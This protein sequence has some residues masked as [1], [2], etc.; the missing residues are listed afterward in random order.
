MPARNCFAAEFVHELDADGK[1]LR[2]IKLTDD[3]AEKVRTLYASSDE[4]S[5][6]RGDA[7]QRAN[8]IHQLAQ[9]ASDY[10]S[11]A[12]Q[13][14]QLDAASFGCMTGE[15]DSEESMSIQTLSSFLC[16]RPVSAPWTS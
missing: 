3:T 12:A 15:N 7:G 14:G 1:H 4:L 16:L 9:S 13:V 2:V 8:M 11:G 6:H 5:A 10:A